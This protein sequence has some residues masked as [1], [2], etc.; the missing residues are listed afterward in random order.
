MITFENYLHAESRDPDLIKWLAVSESFALCLKKNRLVRLTIHES[1][2][3][4][5]STY[6][7]YNPNMCCQLIHLEFFFSSDCK[8]TAQLTNSFFCRGAVDSVKTQETVYFCISVCYVKGS[9]HSG[10]ANVF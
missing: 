3:C 6:N 7:P 9:R 1:Y 2:I 8:L 5:T 4:A 10:T